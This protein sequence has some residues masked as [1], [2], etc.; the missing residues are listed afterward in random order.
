MTSAI[1][2]VPFAPG[3]STRR[4]A[5]GVAFAEGTAV[6]PARAGL[7]DGP[8]VGLAFELTAIE[9]EG[10]A[11]PLGTVVATAAEQPATARDAASAAMIGMV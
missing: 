9:D 8:A 4:H 11:D 2:A 3:S 6:A 10:S 1:R 5:A 7:A